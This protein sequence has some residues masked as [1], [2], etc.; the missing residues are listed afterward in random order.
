MY[1]KYIKSLLEKNK[2]DL[3][4][5]ILWSVFYVILS[6]KY[7]I[8]IY[9]WEWWMFS[10][11]TIA[12]RFLGYKESNKKIDLYEMFMKNTTHLD[13]TNYSSNAEIFRVRD[14]P[15]GTFFELRDDNSH[16]KYI[17]ID[18]DLNSARSYYCLTTQEFKKIDC[19]ANCIIFKTKTSYFPIVKQNININKEE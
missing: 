14:I 7:D 15:I 3:I 8:F 2:L 13:V 5:F 4:A 10:A 17:R 6:F 16:V 9:N 18:D 1:Q 12:F 11:F 19:N